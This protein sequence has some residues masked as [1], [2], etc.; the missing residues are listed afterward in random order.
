MNLEFGA[1]TDIGRNP[2]RTANEDSLGAFSPVA[3][4]I[5][6]SLFVVCDG[7]GGHG[8]GDLASTIA[9]STIQ[10]AY[11]AARSTLDAAAALENAIHAAHQAILKA[12]AA[13]G[14]A[15]NMGTTALAAVIAESEATIGHVGDGRAFRVSAGRVERLTEDH[16]LRTA[17]LHAPRSSEAPEH[18]HVLLRSLSALRPEVEV[19]VR[20]IALLEGEAL[21]L[22]TDGLWAAVP[23]GAI[24]R[25]VGAQPPQAAAQALVRMANRAGGQDNASVIVVLRGKHRGSPDDDT[26]EHQVPATAR[27]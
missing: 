5:S 22:C 13:G 23:E 15:T 17:N 14:R 25:T 6:E 3:E 18:Q 4:G 19:D 8:G 9:V 1:A 27:G 16:T 11:V 24:A 2:R 26:G 12:A 10:R 7:L 20:R 21:V